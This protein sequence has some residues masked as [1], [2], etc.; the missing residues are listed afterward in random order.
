MRI[1]FAQAVSQI[2]L[3]L[4]FLT[5]LLSTSASNQRPDD[6]V[7]DKTSGLRR[8]LGVFPSSS[9]S[10]LKSE[11]IATHKIRTEVALEEQEFLVQKDDEKNYHHSGHHHEH[12][13]EEISEM[14]NTWKALVGKRGREAVK[15]IQKVQPHLLV[16]TLHEVSHQPM[17]HSLSTDDESLCDAHFIECFGTDRR[18]SGSRAGLGQF[19]GESSSSAVPWLVRPTLT[20]SERQTE[21]ENERNSA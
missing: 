11:E 8:G 15:I 5:A 13:D 16:V 7:T 21:T 14:E 18:S 2:L 10:S 4:L 9:P 3:C 17:L 6:H 19:S 20:Q 12:A 1:N